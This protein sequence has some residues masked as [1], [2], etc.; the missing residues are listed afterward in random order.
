MEPDISAPNLSVLQSRRH[1]FAPDGVEE[2][3]QDRMN[4]SIMDRVNSAGEA[5]LSPLLC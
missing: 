1:A 3:E 2:E 4:R 5:F